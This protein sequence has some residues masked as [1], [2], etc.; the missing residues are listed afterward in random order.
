ML[1]ING[2]EVQVDLREELEE[3]NWRN[4]TWTDK[5]LIACSPF[6]EDNHPSFY[7]WLEET[8]KAPL[9]A[10]GDSGGSG[11][12]EKGGFISLLSYL[13]EETEEDTC[14]YLLEKYGVN[15]SE[16]FTL[17]TLRLKKEK[18]VKK[19]LSPT[20]LDNLTYHPYLEKRGIPKAIQK[21]MGVGFDKS[22]NA[23]AIPWKLPN[24][25]LANVKYRRV[26]SKRFFYIRGGWSIGK[27]LFG[28]DIL[29]KKNYLKSVVITEAE[30]DAMSCITVGFPSVAVG[31]SKWS[32]E[33]TNLLIQTN[34]KE[35]IIATD[36][37][38]AGKNLRKQIIESLKGRMK[39]RVVKLPSGHKDCNYVLQRDPQLLRQCLEDANEVCKLNLKLKG[40]K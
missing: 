35:I 16:G 12:Y 37:D 20:L 39:I 14:E 38:E 32:K 4:A 36:N 27:L 2:F 31:G 29:H 40:R 11:H 18:K 13:R 26:D 22:K 34:I 9:G 28:I 21:A 33:K 8:E 19:P 24:G 23:V 25:D 5:K 1:K 3:F 30:I 17:K 15:E 6:R 7:C 10:W